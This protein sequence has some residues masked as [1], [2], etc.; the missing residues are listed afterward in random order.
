[1]GRRGVGG[2][3]ARGGAVGCRRWRRGRRVC[4]L[5]SGGG[6]SRGIRPEKG[7]VSEIMKGERD[8]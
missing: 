8:N 6:S 3:R 5:G 7:Y 4:D 2:E 1:M